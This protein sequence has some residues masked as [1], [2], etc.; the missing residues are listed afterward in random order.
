MDD[1]KILGKD[2]SEPWIE[3]ADRLGPSRAVFSIVP[4]AGLLAEGTTSISP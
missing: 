4:T 2:E 1:A 3:T